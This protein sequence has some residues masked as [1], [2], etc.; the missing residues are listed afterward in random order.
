[1][2]KNV[3]RL[4]SNYFYADGFKNAIKEVKSMFVELL[5]NAAD[6]YDA[7]ARRIG[8]VLFYLDEIEKHEIVDAI[9]E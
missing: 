5:C 4:E 8:D 6:D 1:M 7:N 2:E 9:R 3:I